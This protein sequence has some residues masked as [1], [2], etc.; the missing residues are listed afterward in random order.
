M[1]D[2]EIIKLFVIS[3]PIQ[4]NRNL[5]PKFCIEFEVLLELYVLTGQKLDTNPGVHFAVHQVSIMQLFSP[6]SI[7]LETLW[8][9]TTGTK[10]K[11]L[12]HKQKHTFSTFFGL[13]WL[14][15]ILPSTISVM[16][17]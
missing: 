13:Y 10:D 6:D 7:S 8:L 17:V 1:Y 14:P 15:N 4:W 9:P 12:Y 5:P 3:E 16:V 2:F 11:S